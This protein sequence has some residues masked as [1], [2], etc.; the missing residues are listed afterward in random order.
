MNLIINFNVQEK[1]PLQ[2]G[3]IESI[4]D[5]PIPTIRKSKQ[6][7][8]EQ[9]EEATEDAAMPKNIDELGRSLLPKSLFE[10][11]IVTAVKENVD[12]EELE[13][14]RALTQSKTPAQLAEIKSLGDIPVPDKIKNIFT[15]AGQDKK[16]EDPSKKRR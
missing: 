13:K 1:T 9:D 15:Q 4:G 11:N 5:I 6:H 3:N 14:N 8:T 16:P 7:N 2:L 12:P 10:Q